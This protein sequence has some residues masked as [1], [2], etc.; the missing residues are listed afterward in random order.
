MKCMKDKYSGHLSNILVNKNWNNVLFL[1]LALRMT[2]TESQN[3]RALVYYSGP[4]AEEELDQ[5]SADIDICKLTR[6]KF[7]VLMRF[8]IELSF[9]LRWNQV[10]SFESVINC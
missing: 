8:E 10:I 1:N 3:R 2:Q 5:K 4:P 7:Q 6:V 9:D